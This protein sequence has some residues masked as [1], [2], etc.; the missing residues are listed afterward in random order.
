VDDVLGLTRQA[1][2]ANPR[3]LEPAAKGMVPAL[4]AHRT[5]SGL[6]RD[7][8]CL[9]SGGSSGFGLELAL[10]LA[11]QGVRQVVLLSRRGRVS[12]ED[13]YRLA[14]ARS[15]GCRILEW[16][17]DVADGASLE[18]LLADPALREL[19]LRGVF[20]CAAVLDDALLEDVTPAGLQRVLA[21]KVDGALALH[22]ASLGLD[23]DCFV[24]FSSVSA[25]LGPQGQVAYAAA[26]ACLDALASWRQGQGLPATSIAWGAIGNTGMAARRP[27]VIELLEMQGVVA[28]HTRQ[29]LEALGRVLSEGIQGPI[30]V[31]DVDW[32]RWKAGRGRL[33]Q[34]LADLAGGEA[35]AVNTLDALRQRLLGVEEV[36]RP[37]LLAE[38]LCRQ[39]SLILRIDEKQLQPNQSLAQLGLDSL[40][41]LEWVLAIQQDWGLEVS[42]AELSGTSSPEQLARSVLRRVLP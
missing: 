39:L 38:E 4:P 18:Q 23:L 28:L 35:A 1:S 20:H 7:G 5:P 19:P 16:A 13:E 36:E 37:R 25:I 21:P 26:N 11:R 8:T 27:G 3:W 12:T 14:R 6:R 33:P 9:V 15:A 17:G 31:F 29:A 41:S 42:A 10:W 22:Q 34:R 24:L 30:G 32:H 2:H 40:M